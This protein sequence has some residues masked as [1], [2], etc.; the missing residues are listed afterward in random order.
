METPYDRFNYPGTVYPHAHINRLASMAFLH[1]IKPPDLKSCR[2][3]ELG[4]NRGLHLIGMAL[5]YP[6]AQFVGVDISE[7]SIARANE[8]AEALELTNVVFR[9]MDVT[10][11]SGRPGE[12]DYLIAHGLYSWVPD[13]VR[14]KIL[15]ICG[16]VLADNGVAFISYNAYPG[17]HLRNLVS[18]MMSLHTAGVEDPAEKVKQ[19]IALAATVVR[20]L[21]DD[22]PATPAIK[23]EIQAV[24]SKN[25]VVTYFDEFSSE[26][27]PVYFTD[28]M[29]RAQMNGLQFLSEAE[30][31]RLSFDAL[32]AEA[33]QLLEGITD[34]VV[35]EQYSDFFKL[36]RFRQTLLCRDSLVVDRE[37]F[38]KRLSD[39]YVGSPLRPA[40]EVQIN[41]ESSA[42]YLSQSGGTVTVSQPFVKAVIDELA[43]AWPARLKYAELLERANARL[44]QPQ[45]DAEEMLNKTLFKMFNPNLLEIDVTPYP[46]PPHPTEKPV[47]SKLARLQ[48]A[49]GTDVVSMRHNVVELDD[50]MARTVLRLLDGTRDRK[51]ILD[52]VRLAGHDLDEEALQ[53]MLDRMSALSLLVA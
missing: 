36:T 39:M 40:E 11:L 34:T 42:R 43:K 10:Q 48:A 24:L 51:T 32:S 30:M 7:N 41:N 16:H 17:A 13:T 53:T 46:L 52:A 37:N 29:R 44:D 1:G 38:D 8:L 50:P 2:V 9:A 18:G 26:N 3:L 4:C 45:P 19:G 15:E 5:L 23:A 12:C 25:P 22:N 49:T 28:F 31:T 35:R 6:E 14:E 33:R 27:T 21:G 47:A 20:T